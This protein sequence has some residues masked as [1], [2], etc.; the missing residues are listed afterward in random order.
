M[1]LLNKFYFLLFCNII[2]AFILIIPFLITFFYPLELEV[3]ESTLWL[4]VLTIRDNINLYDWKTVA[5]ANQAYV[6]FDLIFKY[7][8]S[9]LFFL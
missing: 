5:Y 6:P 2:I 9:E 7:L 3:R 1:Q 4:H 8:L